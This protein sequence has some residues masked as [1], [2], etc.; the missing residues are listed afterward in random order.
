MT[1]IFNGE[2][3]DFA[4]L[5]PGSTVQNFVDQLGFQGDRVAVELNGEIVPRRHWAVVHLNA[6]DRLEVVHFVGG[7]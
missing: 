7:G 2:T 6:Q 5:A 4:E 1:L 3:R